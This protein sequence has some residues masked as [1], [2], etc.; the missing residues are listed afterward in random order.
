MMELTVPLPFTEDLL[1]QYLLTEDT[2][3]KIQYRFH[4]LFLFK[5]KEWEN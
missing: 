3:H 2:G 1:N 5:E 4:A